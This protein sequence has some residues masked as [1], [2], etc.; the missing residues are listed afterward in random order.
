MDEKRDKTSHTIK[1][2]H[3]VQNMEIG[4]M[5]NGVVNICNKLDRTKYLPAICCLKGFGPMIDKIKQDVNVVDMGFNEGRDPFRFIRMFKYFKDE[6]PDIVHSHNFYTGLYS[7]PGAKLAGI[8]VIIHGIHGMLQFDK[9]QQVYALKF[10]S[11]ITDCFLNVSETLKNELVARTSFSQKKVK[12]ILNGVNLEKYGRQIDINEKK[13]EIGISSDV[14]VVGSVGRLVPVKNYHLLLKATQ[15][16]S[17]KGINVVYIFIGDGP[18][19]EELVKLSNEYKV[20]AV[21]LGER[22]DI[23]ELLAIMDVFVL[24][25]LSEGM[26]NTILEAMASKLPVIA[27]NV[28][29][30]SILVKDGE[31]GRLVPISDSSK[32]AD[33]IIDVL[34]NMEL[35]RDMGNAGYKH[36]KDNFSIEQMIKKYQQLY[37]YLFESKGMNK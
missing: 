11:A 22:S 14:K 10:L 5:E 7:I 29:N 4:G 18:D 20:N 23:A 17:K 3:I 27:T 33:A 15:I 9:K 19:R 26:S 34:S 6:S 32:L 1:I 24:T 37:K 21:F 35:A 12:T 31:T 28:G 8:P 13:M 16:I 36:I 30:N 25:S 2:I